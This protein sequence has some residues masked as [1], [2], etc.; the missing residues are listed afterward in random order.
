MELRRCVGRWATWG[1]STTHEVNDSVDAW[2]FWVPWTE[3]LCFV[4]DAFMIHK[5][6]LLSIDLQ[7]ERTST[8]K[9]QSVPKI[10]DLGFMRPVYS[11]RLGD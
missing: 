10:R 5:T 8:W 9:Q 4:L 6:V 1:A 11:D 7:L 2:S 3:I